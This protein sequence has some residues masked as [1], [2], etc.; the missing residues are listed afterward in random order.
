[1][2]K[3][4]TIDVNDISSLEPNFIEA[5]ILVKLKTGE[6]GR[7]TFNSSN[8][9]KEYTALRNKVYGESYLLYYSS[10]KRMKIQ[11]IETGK[12]YKSFKSCARENNYP[13][14]KFRESILKTSM[15]KNKKYKIFKA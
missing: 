13:Y 12:I 10:D 5:Y 2:N 8:I 6:K 9:D 3:K 15:Y 14:T 11:C 7:L 4:R 1:M